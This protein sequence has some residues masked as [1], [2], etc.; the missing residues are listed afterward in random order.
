[1]VLLRHSDNH[2]DCGHFFAISVGASCPWVG[3]G[4]RGSVGALQRSLWSYNCTKLRPLLLTGLALGWLLRKRWQ[5]DDWLHL[6]LISYF[7]ENLLYSAQ[8]TRKVLRLC[9]VKSNRCLK[10]NSRLGIICD[11]CVFNDFRSFRKWHSRSFKWSQRPTMR[12]LYTLGIDTSS[13]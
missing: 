3:V 4:G 5:H 2:K 11:W 6:L 7:V 1:M 10:E 9:Q 12:E 8:A 13:E